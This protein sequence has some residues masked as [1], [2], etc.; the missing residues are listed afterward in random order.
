MRFHSSRSRL[1]FALL[2]LPLLAPS[3]ARAIALPPLGGAPDSA[4]SASLTPLPF[5]FHSQ[6]FGWTAGVYLRTT[7]WVQAGA[8]FDVV[9]FGSDNG[10]RYLYHQMRDFRVPGLP[11]L[12]LEP[13]VYAGRFGEIRAYTDGPEGQRAFDGEGEA[14][15]GR[16]GSDENAYLALEGRDVWLR[17]NLRWLLPWADGR[18][19]A[20]VRPR[21]ERGRLVGLPAGGTDWNPLRSGRTF[22]ELEPFRREQLGTVVAGATVSATHENVDFEDDPTRGSWTRL[23]WQRDPGAFGSAAPWSILE[24]DHRSYWPLS[25]GRDPLVLALDAWTAASPTWNDSHGEDGVAVLHRP[26]VFAAPALGSDT[27]L[28]AYY[29]SR[30]NDRAFLYYGAE[31]R[32]RFDSGALERWS[33]HWLQWALFAEAGRVADAWDLREFHRDM[34]P[35]AGGG[36]R[37]LFTD[38]VLR[39]DLAWGEEGPMLQMFMD[40]AF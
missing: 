33:I 15:P 34:K 32:K 14:Y 37:L 22:L 40:Q 28:R 9:L 16:N 3:G 39:L 2:A 10:T 8:Q 1:A 20:P 18:D 7:D 35:S 31:L 4:R 23:A 25:G 19:P 21:L 12:T 36:L 6:F 29:Q 38:L 11:R 13:T 17:A 27:R 5:V 26:P 30:W 24:A